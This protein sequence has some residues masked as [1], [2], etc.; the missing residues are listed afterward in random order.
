MDYESKDMPV[1]YYYEVNLGDGR[2]CLRAI[3]IFADRRVHLMDDLYRDV[4]EAVPIP[5]E[6]EFNAHIWGE[7]FHALTVT[8]NEFEEIWA[9]GVY[10]GDLSFGIAKG[11]NGYEDAEGTD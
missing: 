1:V 4:I 5:T 10:H 6:A 7:Q 8:K 9:C 2:F 11:A 3:E